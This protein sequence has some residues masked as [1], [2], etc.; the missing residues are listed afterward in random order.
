MRFVFFLLLCL[1]VSGGSTARAELP[2]LPASLTD[3]SGRFVIGPWIGSL[4]GGVCQLGNDEPLAGAGLFISGKQGAQDIDI[5]IG[6]QPVTLDL[7]QLENKPFYGH[8][9]HIY[10]LHGFSRALGLF[11][12]CLAGHVPD[13]LP[14]EPLQES[15]PVG[16]VGTSWQ[17]I[18]LSMTDGHVYARYAFL[19]DQRD[20]A[21]GLWHYAQDR[22]LLSLSSWRG[23]GA[24]GPAEATLILP[25]GEPLK[26]PVITQ[27]TSLLL[28]LTAEQIA[29]LA[30]S[31]RVQI[32]TGG[33][34]ESYDL[35]HLP[36]VL[37]FLKGTP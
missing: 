34:D 21:L 13:T 30:A 27:E 36:A 29:R 23:L 6:G 20:V 19:P 10:N 2:G 35:A 28:P 18:T 24:A 25:E 17:A 15:D 5:T 16:I 3:M 7:S 26:T 31:A 14:D 37:A 9:G 1:L 8:D 11:R 22:V 4:Q 33:L 12:E 32:Q